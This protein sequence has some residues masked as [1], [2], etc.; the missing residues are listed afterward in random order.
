MFFFCLFILIHIKY[1]TNILVALK[2]FNKISDKLVR[3]FN[4]TSEKASDTELIAECQP[5]G[6]NVF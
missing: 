6:D 2:H 5:V 1:I 3:R 4:V